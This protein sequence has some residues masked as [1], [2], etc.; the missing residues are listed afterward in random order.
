MNYWLLQANPDQFDVTNYVERFDDIYWSLKK[1]A[2]QRKAAVG[3]EVF[4]WRA[5]GSSKAPS[6]VVAHGYVSEPATE[7][8]KVRH[9]EKLAESLWQTG[10]SEL[11]SIKLGIRLTSRRTTPESGMVLKKHFL[12]D[13]VLSRA[14]IITVR[15]GAVFL[16][17]QPQAQRIRELWFGEG[18]TEEFESTSGLEGAVTERVHRIRERDRSLVSTAKRLFVEKHGRLFCS[19]C[20]FSFPKTYGELG[21]DFIEAHHTKP[22]GERNGATETKVE[23]LVMVCSN[24]HRM[25]HRN[26]DYD[27]NYRRLMSM[28]S[29]PDTNRAS[30]R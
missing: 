3:D 17:P 11:S 16:L 10:Y 27:E 18:A 24:C 12:S 23:D 15:S 19:I 13:P 25:I 8:D 5:Q 26:G 20:Q 7:K 2:W 6:G 30:S 22:V 14:Q 1:E 4:I 21:E 28:F 9:A 29:S